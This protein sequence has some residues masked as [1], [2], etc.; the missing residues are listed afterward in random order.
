MFSFNPD[1]VDDGPMEDG[2]AAFDSYQRSEDDES[3]IEF[4]ELDLNELSLAA[5]E[6]HLCLLLLVCP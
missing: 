2:D 3:E 6:V 4:K 1:L 5:Q